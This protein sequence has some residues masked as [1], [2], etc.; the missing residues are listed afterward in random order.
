MRVPVGVETPKEFWPATS[1]DDASFD[2]PVQG[3]S[4]S[5]RIHQPAFRPP[6]HDVD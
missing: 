3:Y 2:D 1:F 6:R 5:T 4:A